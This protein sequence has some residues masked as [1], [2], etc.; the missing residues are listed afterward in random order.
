MSFLNTIGQ[1]FAHFWNSIQHAY[2]NLEPKVQSAIQSASGIV[3]V[4]NANIEAAPADVWAIITKLYPALTQDVVTS[5]LN[6]VSVD[7]KIAG[8]NIDAD[9]ETTVK[10]LQTYLGT[11]TGNVFITEVKQFVALVAS[12][13]APGNTVIQTIELVLEWVYQTFIK[14][15]V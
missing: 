13:L 12:A 14:G 3:A 15:K 7:L 5:A 6:K 9:F 2:N 11:L 8:A 1:W 10:N 4:I